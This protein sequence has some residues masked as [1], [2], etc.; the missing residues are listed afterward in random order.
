MKCI[1]YTIYI[2]KNEIQRVALRDLVHQQLLGRILHGNLPAGS[3]VK[4]TDLSESMKVSRTPVRE[5][6]LRLVKEGFLENLVGRGFIVRPLTEQEVKDIYPIIS[7]LETLALKTSVPLPGEIVT[8]F[9]VI[10][11]EMET[12]QTD[13]VRLIQLDN[14]W[15]NTLLS[16]CHNQRLIDMIADLKAL[17]FR[18]EYE[19][20][21]HREQVMS[22]IKEHR[23]IVDTLLGKGRTAAVPL[24]EKH[25]ESSQKALL[26]YIKGE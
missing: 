7:A 6:L 14:Q 9:E 21:E 24:L 13:F 10:L 25:W 19:F 16:G 17:A 20:M 11:E 15:H 5:A 8:E 1:L 22:S 4:D 2:M 3:R 18:Y 26:G 12:V 23:A